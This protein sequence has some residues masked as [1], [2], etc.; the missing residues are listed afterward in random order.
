MKKLSLLVILIMLIV[1]AIGCNKPVPEEEDNPLPTSTGL[2]EPTTPV[3]P[4]T[5]PAAPDGTET[6]PGG[7]G[8]VAPGAD[9]ASTMKRDTAN[10]PADVKQGAQLP[11]FTFPLLAGGEGNIEDYIGKPLML[12]FWGID[13]PPCKEELPE[14]VKYYDKY[15]GEGLEIVSLNIDSTPEEQTEFLKTQPMPWVTGYDKAGLFKKW[16]YRGIPTTIFVDP[17]GVVIEIHLGG[18]TLEDMEALKP[19]LFGEATPAAP[20]KP[21]GPTG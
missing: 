20:A 9:S 11:T 5:V 17:K 18:M 3:E 7:E 10:L 12:N 1:L 2:G 14:F 4:G 6:A 16:G 19:K 21:A 15:K 8:P 13:C